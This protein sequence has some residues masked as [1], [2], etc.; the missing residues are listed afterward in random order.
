MSGGLNKRIN[1]ISRPTCRLVS[2]S[3]SH[4]F[5]SWCVVP[6]VLCEATVGCKRS[7]EEKSEASDGHLVL[8]TFIKM[9]G[10]TR[11]MKYEEW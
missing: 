1:Q 7:E 11:S 8:L 5:F 6:S 3:L 9:T 10:K 2:I 4:F